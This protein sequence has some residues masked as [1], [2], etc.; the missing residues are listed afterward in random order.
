MNKAKLLAA[1]VLACTSIPVVSAT[2][3]SEVSNE[4]LVLCANVS[5]VNGA[6]IT[7]RTAFRNYLVTERNY[8]YSNLVELEQEYLSGITKVQQEQARKAYL[9]QCEETGRQLYFKGF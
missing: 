8:Q 4:Q 2:E 6:S 5:G 7:S 1:L 3:L 9:E